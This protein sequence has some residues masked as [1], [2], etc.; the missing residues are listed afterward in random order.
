MTRRRPFDSEEA[1]RQRQRRAERKVNPRPGDDEMKKAASK[2]QWEKNKDNAEYL[3]ERNNRLQE[4]RRARTDL[5]G[6]STWKKIGA[7]LEDFYRFFEAQ[8]GKCAIC[9]KPLHDHKV[10]DRSKVTHF[11]HCHATGKL[12]GLLCFSCNNKLG[13]VEKYR[14][15]INDYLDKE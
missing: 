11:D 13:F 5:E 7:T 4:R 10:R 15:E 8:D 14:Q 9:S 12:R 1:E 3:A 6:P 2:R